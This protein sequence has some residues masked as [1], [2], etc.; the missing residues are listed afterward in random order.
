[1]ELIVYNYRRTD[2]TLVKR[3]VESVCLAHTL[4]NNSAMSCARIVRKEKDKQWSIRHNVERTRKIQLQ[5]HDPIKP[6]VN[7]CT[8]KG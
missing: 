6:E 5:Q 1:M 3:L 4:N 7:S 2:N 8:P